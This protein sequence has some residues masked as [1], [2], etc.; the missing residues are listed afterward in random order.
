M[1]TNDLKDYQEKAVNKLVSRTQE[2]LAESITK[3]TIVFKSPTGSGKTFMMSQYIVQLIKEV[4]D[5]QFCFLWVSIGKGGLHEQSYRSLK[6]IF[7][8]YP[9][10]YLLEDEFSGARQ[11][12]E[13]NEVVVVNWNKLV[14]KDKETG[15]WKNTLMKDKETTNFRELMQNTREQGIKIVLIID[16]SHTSASSERAIELRD[17]I[18]PEITIEVSATPVLKEGQYNEKVE[19]QPVDVIEEGMIKKE[20]VVNE[21]IDLV[22]D[23]TLNSTELVLQSAFQKRLAL[24]YGF[25]SENLDINPLVLVQIATSDEGAEKRVVIEQ[26]LAEK[27]CTINNGKVAI[28][29][30]EDQKNLEVLENNS[31]EVDFVIFKQAIDTGWDCPRAQILVKFRETKSEVFELQ[32]IGRILRMPEAH[33]YDDDLLNRAYIYTNVQADYLEFEGKE[34]WLKNQIKSIRM[35][36]SPEYKPLHLR[37]YYRNRIDY[38]DLTSSFYPVLLNVF[39]TCFDIAPESSGPLFAAANIEKMRKGGVSVELFNK[40]ASLI[41]NKSIDLKYFENLGDEKMKVESNFQASL[42][43]D[44]KERVFDNIIKANLNGYA[45]KRSSDIFYGALFSWFRKYTDIHAAQDGGAIKIQNIVLNHAEIF[46]E[47]F[48]RA[49]E[50]YKPIKDEEIRKKIEEVEMWNDEWEIAPERGFSD[51]YKPFDAELALYKREADKKTYLNV[52]STEERAFIEMLEK[53][54]DKIEWWWQNGNEHMALNFG[55]KY[56]G[57]STF[58]PDF[59]VLFKDGRLGIFDTKAVGYMEEDTKQK[60]EALQNYI[61]EENQ[62]RKE[63]PLVGGI[64]ILKDGHFRLNS[65]ELYITF[66]ESTKVQ[67]NGGQMYGGK[68]TVKNWQYFE[69]AIL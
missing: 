25:E 6:H 3:R 17:I 9:Q 2:L 15:E 37:S 22:G 31:S 18:A 54:K 5:Q 34:T 44:D 38:G 47:L 63:C 1:A 7:D 35:K 67:D 49:V 16:E 46:G 4:A 60:A 50:Q 45:F 48:N 24:K 39:C 21:G 19:V 26:F 29:L 57:G 30:H 14:N 62:R 20:V 11:V 56:G 58:Q 43:D 64:V 28:W 8:G 51:I 33:H 36:R 69:S 41:L 55:V 61:V 12:I 42:S 32:T 59:L 65:D 10:C 40:Q 52:D 66:T 23:G 27:G 13:R 53:H 68:S